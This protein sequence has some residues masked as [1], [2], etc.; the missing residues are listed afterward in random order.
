MQTITY[1]FVKKP[2]FLG[3]LDRNLKKL[4][5]RLGLSLSLRGDCLYVDG[6]P[7]KVAGAKAYFDKVASWRRKATTS[8]R[9]TSTSS[10]TF[11]KRAGPSPSNSTSPPS[12]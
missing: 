8:R 7:A 11:S 9:T 3:V 5:D 2:A 6:E 4:E 10:S 12:P 1:P